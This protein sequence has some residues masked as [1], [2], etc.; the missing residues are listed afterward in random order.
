MANSSLTEKQKG[1]SPAVKY[2]LDLSIGGEYCN[3]LL[4]ADLAVEAEQAG[5]DGVFLWD[6]VFAADEP[7]W[8]VTETWIVLA[9][10]A[11]R[12]QRI[13]IGALAGATWWVEA[14]NQWAGPFEERRKRIRIGPPKM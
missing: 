6:C 3:P 14:I 9:V 13:R 11:A 1:D 4:L 7:T 2:G 8:P 10:I 12:T 5:W